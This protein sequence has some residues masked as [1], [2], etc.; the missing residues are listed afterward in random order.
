MSFILQPWHLLLAAVCGLVNHRQQQ[1]IEFQN[2]QIEALLKK[3]R[4]KRVLLD[5]DQRRLLAVKGHAIGRKALH[6]LTTIVTPDTILR[7]HRKLVAK[8]FDS[9]DK[10]KPGRPRSFIA[11]REFVDQN[12]D[13]EIVLLPPKIPNL[14]AYME[15]WFRSLKSECLDRMIF[16]GPRSLERAVANF[17][18]HY[19]A[20]RNHQG[21]GNVLIEPDEHVG[22]TAGSIECHQRLGGML[23]YYVG[24]AA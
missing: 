9:S 24:R 11:L 21:L 18:Q 2:I 7:W 12:T 1:I 19:H 4:R 13:T 8:K 22:S 17:I 3:L 10:R 15:R 6:E 20:E 23:K 5:D 14:N 16:F